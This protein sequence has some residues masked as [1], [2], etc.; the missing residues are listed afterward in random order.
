M[1]VSKRLSILLI[2]SIFVFCTACGNKNNMIVE[3]S[4]MVESLNSDEIQEAEES[5]ETNVT[6]PHPAEEAP[7][8]SRPMQL[9]NTYTT[10]YA[11]VNAITY[12]NFVFDYPDNWQIISEKVDRLDEKVIL[13]NGAGVTITFS[14]IGGIPEGQLSGESS[15][16]MLRMDIS[17]AGDSQFIPSMVQDTDYSEL[18]KFMVAKL[19]VTGQLDMY[20]DSDFQDVDGKVSYAVLPE[21]WAGTREDVRMAFEAEFAFWYSGYISVIATKA[22]SQFTP[23]EAEEVLAIL[24]SFRVE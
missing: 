6:P 9:N 22:D 2:S 18:G 5:R 13:S 8:G 24:G 15:V 20:T 7:E 14:H 19:K 4:K 10:K 1:T 21:S 17:K 16:S 3:D 11:E 12:P 23:D